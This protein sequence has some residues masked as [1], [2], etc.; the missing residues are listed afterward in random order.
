MDVY[1]LTACDPEGRSCSDEVSAVPGESIVLRLCDGGG[2]L[3]AARDAATGE[4]RSVDVHVAGPGTALSMQALAHPSP[5]ILDG[6]K[7]GRYDVVVQAPNGDI[8]VAAGVVVQVG[9]RLPVDIPLRPSA[10]L[11]VHCG[12]ERPL[13]VRVLHS[14]AQLAE[15]TCSS[16][17]AAQVLVPPGEI[18]VRA[19][20]S[21]TRMLVERVVRVEA[22]S[23]TTLDIED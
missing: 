8:G 7:P 22:G 6:L 10:R 5:R 12:R 14:G 20:E 11:E 23:V 3:I 16:D 15:E 19:F 17:H 21:P 9:H 1:A 4:L 13:L 2:L 18:V